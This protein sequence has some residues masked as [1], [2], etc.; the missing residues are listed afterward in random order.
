VFG[1]ALHT[2]RNRAAASIIDR[3]T[4]AV[5]GTGWLQH[6]PLAYGYAWRQKRILGVVV[7]TNRFFYVNQGWGGEDNGWVPAGTWFVGEIWP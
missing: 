3:G 1:T 6:Y 2:L 5:I 7:Q 4:P